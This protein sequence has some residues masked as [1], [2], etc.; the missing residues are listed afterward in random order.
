MLA[1]YI[2]DL[3][4]LRSWTERAE[5]DLNNVSTY[6]L[7]IVSPMRDLAVPN[8]Y[9]HHELNKLTIPDDPKELLIWNQQVGPKEESKLHQLNSLQS[10]CMMQMVEKVSILPRP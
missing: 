8:S 10:A 6:G 5:T 9:I 7:P 3:R 1:H 2:N 4:H